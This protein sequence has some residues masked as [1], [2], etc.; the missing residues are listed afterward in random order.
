MKKIRFVFYRAKID[1]HALDDA[2]NIWTWTLAFISFQWNRLKYAYSHCEIWLPDEDYDGFYS[3]LVLTS[4]TT[5]GQTGI[6]G[7]CF[8]STTRDNA[9]GVRFALASE[10]LKHPDRWDYIEVEITDEKYNEMISAAKV[11][12]GC[13]YD[14]KGLFGFF[15]F[16]DSQDP[17]KWYCSEICSYLA[18]IIGLITLPNYRISPRRLAKVLADKLGEPKALN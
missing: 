3:T 13:L 2:I 1:G 9:K 8:S 11:E 14:Y 4:P 10:V 16:R 15:W 5:F 7:Q 6:I 18:C 17:E 12:E